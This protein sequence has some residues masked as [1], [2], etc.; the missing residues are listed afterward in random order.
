MAEERD[1]CVKF[2][3][4]EFF[5]VR[6]EETVLLGDPTADGAEVGEDSR[7]FSG[8]GRVLLFPAVEFAELGGLAAECVDASVDAAG[9]SAGGT[10]VRIWLFGLH[11]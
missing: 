5:G 10:S 1:G 7:E 2:G 6:V 4:A 11:Q 3:D 9:R 8:R